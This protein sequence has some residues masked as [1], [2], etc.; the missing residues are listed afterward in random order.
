MILVNFIGKDYY[1]NHYIIVVED[2]LL[3]VIAF[4]FAKNY[5]NTNVPGY[6]YNDRK[7]SITHVNPTRNHII[8]KS[9]SF[10]LYFNCLYRYIKEFNKDRNYLYNELQL[11]GFEI[12]KLKEYNIK[13][14]LHNAT[15][16]FKEIIND[17]KTSNIFKHYIKTNYKILLQ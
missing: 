16:M 17:N 1:N 8:R 13:N 14:Y 11:F 15:E 6:M 10:F 12:I 4:Q 5:S 2:T 3:N 7:F 9:V